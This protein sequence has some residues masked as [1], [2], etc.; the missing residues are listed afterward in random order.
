MSEQI[1][2]PQV[3]ETMKMMRGLIPVLTQNELIEL[4][5]FNQ[6]VIDRY[7]KEHYPNGLP[8]EEEE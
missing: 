1:S 3:R 6:K 4:M 7:V 5:A 2:V 8:E